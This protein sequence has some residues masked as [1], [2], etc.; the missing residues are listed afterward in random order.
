MPETTF[1]KH[2]AILLANA[3]IAHAAEVFGLKERFDSP[4]V[5][6]VD[7]QGIT[8]HAIRDAFEQPNPVLHLETVMKAL[9]AEL[10]SL[11]P[12]MPG[13][14]LANP[15]TPVG[16]EDRAVLET[17]V[18]RPFKPKEHATILLLA[19]EGLNVVVAEMQRGG[20]VT[21]QPSGEQAANDAAIA[22]PETSQTFGGRVGQGERMGRE[23]LDAGA[24]TQI[25][26]LAAG[27]KFEQAGGLESA[28]K[29]D[30]TKL[31]DDAERINRSI[32][33][34]AAKLPPARQ[35]IY[36]QQHETA[37]Q[38]VVES[39]PAPQ[40]VTDASQL[41]PA[42]PESLDLLKAHLQGDEAGQSALMTLSLEGLRAMTKNVKQTRSN[43]G[44]P[45]FGP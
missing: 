9:S 36:L 40:G 5:L 25:A 6:Q 16:D 13:V 17:Y 29:G 2:D 21:Q 39:L 24:L 12:S 33:E 7:A 10:Q 26:M 30:V 23:P 34:E 44:V 14:A 22:T 35:L 3:D 1:S 37:L 41:R 8:G 18:P 15:L 4:A 32:I 20:V 42:N 45:P 27:E 19:R 31:F 43:D 38:D 28:Y 11:P